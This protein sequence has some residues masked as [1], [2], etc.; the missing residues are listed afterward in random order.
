MALYKQASLILFVLYKLS[1]ILIQT[2]VSL[3]Q[4][5]LLL[6]VNI[7]LYSEAIAMATLSPNDPSSFSRPGKKNLINF[8]KYIN[9]I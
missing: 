5:K 4:W 2:M 1:D 8:Q 9:I 3:S 6:T 7:L